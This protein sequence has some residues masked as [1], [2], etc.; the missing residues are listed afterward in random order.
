MLLCM[1]IFPF[2]CVHV[3]LEAFDSVL[4]LCLF[5]L[6]VRVFYVAHEICAFDMNAVYILVFVSACLFMRPNLYVILCVCLHA[7]SVWLHLPV[8]TPRVLYCVCAPMTHC[9]EARNLR[10][11]NG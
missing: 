11:A 4:C 7:P 2:A 9:K 10:P 6:P 5:S 3:P 8:C 1:N